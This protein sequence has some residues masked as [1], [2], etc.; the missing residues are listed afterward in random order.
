[1]TF[2]VKEVMVVAALAFG[3]V[4]TGCSGTPDASLAMSPPLRVYNTGEEF[5]CNFCFSKYEF[6]FYHPEGLP[7]RVPAPAKTVE[8]EPADV[9]VE[10]A[11][12]QAE[13]EN[14]N[15]FVSSWKPSIPSFLK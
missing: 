14:S 5:D 8:K 15:S 3:V 4:V 12:E 6:D 1:M 10:V 7:K 2:G 13:P 11:Q 9:P